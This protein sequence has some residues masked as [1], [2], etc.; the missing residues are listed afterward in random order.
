MDKKIATPRF[1]GILLVLMVS[2][3]LFA[4]AYAYEGQVIIFRDD[5]AQPIWMV[6]VTL[7]NLTN[8][9]I[10]NGIPQTIG[11]IPNTSSGYSLANDANFRDYL[12]SIK[13]EPTVELALHGYNH[14]ENEFKD[15]TLEQAESRIEWGVSLMQSQLGVNPKTFIPPYHEFNENTLNACA[16]HGFTGFSAGVEEPHAWEEYPEG[17][18]HV[19]ATADFEDW[20]NGGVMK[21]SEEVIE[22]CEDSLN[23]LNVCIIM[24]HHWKFSE[25]GE[26]VSPEHYQSMLEVIEWA[27]EKQS[28]GAKLMTLGEYVLTLSEEDNTTNTTVN[29]TTNTTVNNTTNTTVNNT[30]N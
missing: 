8:T 22:D 1:F 23:G 18:F 24:F 16:S 26:N 13:S 9:L 2:F 5:D 10:Q 30:T 15:I 3:S 6:N 4:P 17:L 28:Q 25:D 7:K 21:G 19:P 29:N 11:V 14:E 12:N 20:D 27:K